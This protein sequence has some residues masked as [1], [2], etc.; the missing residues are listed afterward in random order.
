MMVD[1][2]GKLCYNHVL[3]QTWDVNDYL[4]ELKGQLKTWRDVYWRLWGTI[5]CAKCARCGEYF[6]CAELGQCRFHPEHAVYD[7]D[8]GLSARSAIGRFQCCGVSVLRF[9]PTQPNKVRGL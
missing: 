9:D 3:D 7:T 1:R 6:A 4:I 8:S 2:L 5:N